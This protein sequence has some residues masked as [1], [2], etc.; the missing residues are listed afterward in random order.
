MVD[1][2]QQAYPIQLRSYMETKQDAIARMLPESIGVERFVQVA[3]LMATKR[4][5]LWEVSPESLLLAIMESARAGLYIDG[6]EATIIPFKG[7][8]QFMPMVQGIVR[9]M[10]RAPKVLKIEA[11]GVYDGDDLKFEYGLDPQ[12]KH[13]PRVIPSDELLTHAYAIVWKQQTEPQFEVMTREE[14]EIVRAS[15]RAKTGP[16]DDWYGEMSRKTVVKRLSKYI[17]LSPEAQKAIAIDHELFGDPQMEGYVD[18]LSDE[19][20][21]AMVKGDTESRIEELKSQMAESGDRDFDED[22]KDVEEPPEDGPKGNQ[23]EPGSA[24][25]KSMDVSDD[26]GEGKQGTIEPPDEEPS[27]PDAPT[28]SDIVSWIAQ[29]VNVNKGKHKADSLTKTVAM[30]LGECF[31][32]RD[33]PDDDR[34]RFVLAVF[35]KASL[36]DLTGAELV[37]VLDFVEAKLGKDKKYH[38]NATRAQQARMIADSVVVS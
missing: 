25:D 5:D 13:T 27:D 2:D 24:L 26:F 38:P 22:E 32:G 29:R 37:S 7:Q 1:K 33:K 30:T 34:H 21:N 18:G 23:L 6:K 28:V 4:K 31:A 3:L 17:D 35:E 16:W 15:S 8:A 36:N 20:R 14:I 9:L 19:Y 10:L 12:L 11:R